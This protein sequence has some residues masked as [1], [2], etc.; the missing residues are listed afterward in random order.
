ML[1]DLSHRPDR[2][3]E[4]VT[5]RMPTAEEM[6]LLRL[7]PNVP[8]LSVVRITRDKAG[9]VL[10]ALRIL[11]AAVRNVFVYDDLPIKA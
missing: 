9:Q 10:Q 1:A 3:S 11:A 5:A 4:E 8:V 7:R 6:E 2:C